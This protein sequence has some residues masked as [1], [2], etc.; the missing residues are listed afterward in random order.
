MK[1]DKNY[2]SPCLEI[3]EVQV[4]QAVLSFS[5]TGEGVNDD[6]LM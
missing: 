6:D 2:E 5:L 3:I 4:E 1:N